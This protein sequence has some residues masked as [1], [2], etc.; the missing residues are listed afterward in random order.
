MILCFFYW[1][2]VDLVRIDK[3]DLIFNKMVRNSLKQVIFYYI[4][5]CWYVR[6]VLIV[7]LSTIQRGRGSISWSIGAAV[8]LYTLSNLLLFWD[9]ALLFVVFSSE[10]K[11]NNALCLGQIQK[12]YLFSILKCYRDVTVWFTP[13]FI[14]FPL[15]HNIVWVCKR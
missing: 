5:H 10:S 8:L 12:F 2:K 13:L 7:L 3:F 4:L 9:H 1:D 6:L 11:Q 14:T 15:V